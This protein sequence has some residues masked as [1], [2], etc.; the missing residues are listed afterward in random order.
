MKTIINQSLF[1]VGGLLNL[2]KF[3]ALNVFT[4]LSHAQDGRVSRKDTLLPLM[5]ESWKQAV[6]PKNQTLE[7]CLRAF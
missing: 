5:V 1:V 2:A 3:G 4:W 7:Y 6:T